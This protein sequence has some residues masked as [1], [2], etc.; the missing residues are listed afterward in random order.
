MTE[1]TKKEKIPLTD[2]GELVCVLTVPTF[3]E[4]PK[5]TDFYSKLRSLCYDRCTQKLPSL[6][7]SQKNTYRYR[8]SFKCG[9]DGD[10]VT[11]TLSVTLSDLTDRRQLQKHLETHIWKN[12]VLRKRTYKTGISKK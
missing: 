8:L 11:V 12:G 9:S 1:E 5:M 3:E 7:P 6:L 2:G 4:F 10:A